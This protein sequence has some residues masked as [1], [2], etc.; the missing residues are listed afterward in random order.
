VASQSKGSYTIKSK[1]K[2]KETNEQFE[3][4]MILD[5]VQNY[6]DTG[7]S[8]EL[9]MRFFYT[10]DAFVRQKVY[11]RPLESNQLF[12]TKKTEK[13]RRHVTTPVVDRPL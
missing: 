5:N 1:N 7:K 2:I 9:T 8:F 6:K 13:K 11:P 3:I 10:K 4:D 12:I